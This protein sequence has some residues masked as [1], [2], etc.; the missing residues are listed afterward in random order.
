M[1]IRALG[2]Y[3]RKYSYK[4]MAD[5]DATAAYV[6]QSRTIISVLADMYHP[7]NQV[8]FTT[9][10]EALARDVPSSSSSMGNSLCNNHW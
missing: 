7:T 8:T 9:D 2:G 10:A 1:K 6:D 4:K 3:I 5:W